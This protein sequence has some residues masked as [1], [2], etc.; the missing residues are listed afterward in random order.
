MWPSTILFEYWSLE[1]GSRRAY[2]LYQCDGAS[3]LAKT[4]IEY[5]SI[6]TVHESIE[7]KWKIDPTRSVPTPHP[8]ENEKPRKNVSLKSI[9]GEIYADITLVNDAYKT[10]QV[11]SLGV[12]RERTVIQI[13]SVHRAITTKI[14]RFLIYSTRRIK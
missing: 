8:N 1:R 10:G 7:V 4:P 3:L 14:V 13:S 9:H 5:A 6:T 12:E 11:P 2:V